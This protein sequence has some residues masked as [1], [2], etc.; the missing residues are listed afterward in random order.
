MKNI[1]NVLLTV[2]VL[3][4]SANLYGQDNEIMKAHY[5]NVG[6]GAAAL[7]EFPCGVVMIDAGAQ[8]DEY[9]KKL[10]DYLARFFKR[11]KDLN[12]TIDLL[13][14]THPHKDHN[15]ALMDIATTYKV[16]RYIDDGMRTGSGKT[17]QK[18]LQDNAKES[19]IAYEAISFDEIAGGGNKKGMTDT[20]IDPINC[21]NVDPKIIMYS[22]RFVKQ[23]ENWGKSAFENGNNHSLV[24]KVLFGKSSF[25]FTGDLETEGIEKLLEYY[26]ASNVLDTDVLLVGHH[27]A[28]N[29]TTIEYLKEVT[30]NIAVISCGV[31]DFGK[32][33]SDKFTTYA[34][35]HPRVS[36]IN[37]LQ[38]N[39]NGKKSDAVQ[40]EAAEGAR[41]FRPINIVKKL[42]ATPWDENIIIR[43]G[44]N[45]KYTVLT[46]N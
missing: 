4:L 8:D 33:A 30:P 44:T 14:V 21:P 43:A 22:G 18:W 31:W 28:K 42:Y 19:D 1:T 46:D 36:T 29:A 15:E 2:I 25:L 12:N 34:Y 9:H 27:G 40:V 32:G 41:D 3:A 45:G 39:I 23:P 38:D 11:R 10:M 16:E 24:V 6:Q 5:I 26:G 7:L 13:L 20:I 35:G 37:M 17:N